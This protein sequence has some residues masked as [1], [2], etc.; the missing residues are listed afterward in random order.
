MF[1]SL[2]F[3]VFYIE[4]CS[5]DLARLLQEQPLKK[6]FNSREFE[7]PGVSAQPPRRD[8]TEV[9]D[10]KAMTAKLGERMM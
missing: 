7:E 9:A 6:T 5:N 3:S 8:L 10:K 1:S 4:Q 2:S